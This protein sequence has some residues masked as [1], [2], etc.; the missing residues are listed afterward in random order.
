MKQTPKER[1][2][3]LLESY[4]EAIEAITI[5]KY[6]SELDLHDAAKKCAL[7]CVDRILGIVLS[8]PYQEENYLVHWW[9]EVKREVEK[10]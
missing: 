2:L 4:K 7:L 3:E 8:K 5:P 10:L 1:A 6:T 9:L